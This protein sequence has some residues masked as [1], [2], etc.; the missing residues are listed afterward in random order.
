MFSN[1][2][3]HMHL[4]LLLATRGFRFCSLQQSA[5]E[6]PATSEVNFRFNAELST[7]F[8]QNDA[9]MVNKPDVDLELLLKPLYTFVY[10]D[11]INQIDPRGTDIYLK[12]GNNS[13]NIINDL[14]HQNV[15]VD[16]YNDRCCKIGIMCFSFAKTGWALFGFKSHWLGWQSTTLAG[17][18]MEGTIYEAD[19]A[20]TVVQTKQTTCRQDMR[21]EL[22][23]QIYRVGTKD[24][25][26]LARHNCR[27]YSQKEF[28]D[29]PGNH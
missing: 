4:P 14:I 9:P 25:Y 24:V 17:L 18:L 26:S 29:A 8:A 19:D 12:T 13:G 2:F 10:N 20:G 3:R 22:W 23:M 27:M 15:C 11:P 28:A 16:R 1:A 21:W 7:L 5:F 6:N